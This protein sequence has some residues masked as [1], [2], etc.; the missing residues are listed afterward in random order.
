MSV[1]DLYKFG[2]GTGKNLQ[3]AGSVAM[4]S[5]FSNIDE[6]NTTATETFFVIFLHRLC[7]K[8]YVIKAQING[9]VICLL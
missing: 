8:R 6:E 3:I 4:P 5:I 2:N 1:R 9:F 7:F